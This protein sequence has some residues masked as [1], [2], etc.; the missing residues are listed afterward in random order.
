MIGCESVTGVWVIGYESVTGM[1]GDWIWVWAAEVERII[2]RV[3][4]VGLSLVVFVARARGA[5]SH[6]QALPVPPLLATYTAGA[7]R[8]DTTCGVTRFKHSHIH[9][10]NIQVDAALNYE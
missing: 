2:I 3:V 10:E 8:T 1:R 6:C 5:C 7:S 9:P 4:Q